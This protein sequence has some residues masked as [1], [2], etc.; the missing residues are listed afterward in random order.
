[1]ALGLSHPCTALEKWQLIP[2]VESDGTVRD[3]LRTFF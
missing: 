3:Y 2:E 1:V